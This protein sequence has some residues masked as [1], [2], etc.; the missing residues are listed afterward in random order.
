VLQIACAS[1]KEGCGHFGPQPPREMTLD[2][3]VSIHAPV[4][5][6]P[7]RKRRT[8]LVGRHFVSSS[9]A[10]TYPKVAC[11]CSVKKK[12]FTVDYMENLFEIRL[13]VE[14]CFRE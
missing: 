5:G 11:L 1:R 14:Y 8:E 4:K 13:R 10:E 6:R 12:R 7:R 9:L 3:M 2:H